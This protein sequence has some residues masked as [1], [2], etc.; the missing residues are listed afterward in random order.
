MKVSLHSILYVVTYS[1]FTYCHLLFIER[2]K[3]PYLLYKKLALR[4]QYSTLNGTNIKTI[5][6]I[7]NILKNAIMRVHRN[8]ISLQNPCHLLEKLYIF[9]GWK[10]KLVHVS[11]QELV[12]V[13]VFEMK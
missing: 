3:G 12:K 9:L 1:V 2:Q 4:T 6:K 13:K 8:R 5:G 7:N 11:L 10:M